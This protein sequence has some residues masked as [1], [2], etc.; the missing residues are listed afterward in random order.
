MVKK[1]QQANNVKRPWSMVSLLRKEE[2]DWLKSNVLRRRLRHYWFYREILKG[3]EHPI[4]YGLSLVTFFSLVIVLWHL[5]PNDWFSAYWFLWDS[6]EQL[7]YFTSLWSVQATLAALVY[8]FIIAFVALLL[9]RRPSSK[10]FLQIYLIDSG[11]LVAGLSSLFL[12][13]FMALQYVMLPT[14]SLGLE[15]SWVAVDSTWFIYNIVLT[16]WF[17]F[18][19]VEFLR[20]DFQME[21]VK[22]YVANV[23]L[24]REIANL[25]RF[26]FFANAQKNGWIP[27]PE[28]LDDASEGQPQV[29]MDSFGLDMGVAEVERCLRQ[30]SRLS[31]VFFWPLRLA[32]SGWLKKARKQKAIQG[33]THPDKAKSPLLV[34]PLLPGSTYEAG[35]VLARIDGGP[36][37]SPLQRLLVRMSFWFTPIR[38][39]RR[40]VT[41][42]EVLAELETDARVSAGNGDVAAF[43]EAYGRV[44]EM[45]QTLLGASLG[46][47][48]DGSVGSWALVSDGLRHVHEHWTNTYRSLFD[49]AAALLPK[50]TRPICLLCRLVHDLHGP[51]LQHSPVEIRER[52][53]LL[54]SQL[55]YSLANWWSQRLEEQGVLQHGSNDMALLHP[56]LQGAY[57]ETLLHF[58]GGW[59]SA[60]AVLADFPNRNAQFIWANAKDLIKLNIR[61]IN[62][63]GLMLLRAVAR[64]DQ[65]AGEWLADVMSKWLAN[66]SPYD[67]QP[68]KLYR[69]SNFITIETVSHEWNVVEDVLGFA[70][71]DRQDKSELQRHICFA[72]LK[73][74]WRDIRLLTL[75]ILLSWA[76]REEAQLG[77]RSLAVYVVNGLLTGRQWRAG[78]ENKEPLTSLT[79]SNY[80]TMKARQYGADSSYR[81]GYVAQLNSFVDNAKDILRPDMV[82]GQVYSYSG[83]NDV[84]SLQEAQLIIFVILSFA[85]WGP[86]EALRRQLAVWTSSNFQSTELVKHRAEAMKR[87]LDEVGDALCP[88]LVDRLLSQMDKSHTRPDGIARTRNALDALLS[89]IAGL[90]SDAV[91]GAEVSPHRLKEIEEAASEQGF[92]KDTGEFPL[93]LFSSITYNDALQEPFTLVISNLRKGELTDVEMAQRAVNERESYAEA[94]ANAVGVLLL[95]DVLHKSE[96]RDVFAPNAAAYWSALKAEAKTLQ[97]LGL[98]PV[99][100]LDNPTRPDWVWEWE[101][102]T[103]QDS[104]YPRPPDLV[105]R[106]EE[107]RGDGYLADFND[108]QV[109]S[110]TVEPGGSLLFAH[111]TFSM[112]TFRKYREDIFVKAVASEVAGSRTL[113]D[114][115]LTFE[116]LVRVKHNK[117]VRIRYEMANPMSGVN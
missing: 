67:Q 10:A 53:L 72:A 84:E 87:R 11:G 88:H 103:S 96:I 1:S 50:E 61:H 30:R 100:V 110:G 63:T 112:V 78:G 8:P 42:A 52:T 2:R 105:I 71:N 90:Q 34:L 44:M 47:A 115:R 6:A 37:F 15:V 40:H 12:V 75:E 83:A 108:I 41:S 85:E 45:H 101:F 106:H 9:Q 70:D 94:V 82:P 33:T 3:G 60:R 7:S 36:Q 4:R 24:P 69:K 23:A 51:D 73:N 109:F 25:L 97:E 95:S 48:D 113:V 57:E 104:I 32:V 62:Q 80:L 16:L 54:P 81:K 58:V 26:H 14:Y 98:T 59:D 66:A 29:L 117:I 114:L 20:S 22:G 39:E 86:E 5:L 19:T 107:G 46:E 92:S 18:R 93:Q 56:P 27:G 65:C 77:E 111:E 13:L 76:A 28:Y 35:V 31:N 55:M 17:L 79:A 43:E 38:L 68:F 99:L 49:A 64:G 21:V 74:Y 91:A 102:P 116:R 89:E